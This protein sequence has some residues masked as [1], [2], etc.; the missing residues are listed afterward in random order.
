MFF[1][2][3]LSSDELH[4]TSRWATSTERLCGGGWSDAYLNA[5]VNTDSTLMDGSSET[6]FTLKLLAV[7][8]LL[9]LPVVMS[10]QH[11]DCVF[12]V[13]LN[14]IHMYRNYSVL[15]NCTVMHGNHRVIIIPV[16]I[17]Q[18]TE[19]SIVSASLTFRRLTDWIRLL[20]KLQQVSITLHR[21]QA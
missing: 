15:L 2:W 5:Y 13:Y 9:W 10:V 8:I 4:L 17:M 19:C 20:Q 14:E 1:S 12:T 18:W 16:T 3:I 21:R 11:Q 6:E 7:R